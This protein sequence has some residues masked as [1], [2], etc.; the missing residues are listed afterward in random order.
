MIEVNPDGAPM[1]D[2]P[3]ALEHAPRSG[4][5]YP[6]TILLGDRATLT[7]PKILRSSSFFNVTCLY[8]AKS[9]DD[10]Q[11][12]AAIV[13]S[14]RPKM[15]SSLLTNLQ[16]PRPRPGPPITWSPI[17]PADKSSPSGPEHAR[18]PSSS[19]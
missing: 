18:G 8:E 4:L 3:L 15:L 7:N 5:H 17:P 14:S 13:E 12:G 11:I 10:N 19:P 1:I 16:L 6:R 2:Q 9:T